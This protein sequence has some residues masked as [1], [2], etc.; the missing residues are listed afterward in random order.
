MQQNMS[1]QEHSGLLRNMTRQENQT[2]EQNLE[3]FTHIER[4]DES[5]S[6]GTFDESIHI[7]LSD[8]GV[9][10]GELNANDSEVIV[11]Q[12]TR[13][14][15]EALNEVD[16]TYWKRDN[17]T[18]GEQNPMTDAHQV[19]INS[20]E[21]EE[22]EEAE[23]VAVE[24]VRQEML[25]WEEQS[26]FALN[27]SIEMMTEENNQINKELD[28]LTSKTVHKRD[29]MAVPAADSHPT[30][31]RQVRAQ[32]PVL[33]A[34]PSLLVVCLPVVM[35]VAAVLV[36]RLYWRDG[37]R[38]RMLLDSEM[39]GPCLTQRLSSHP[40]IV[41]EN[42]YRRKVAIPLCDKPSFTNYYQDMVPRKRSFD[43]EE[44]R[45]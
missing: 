11:I 4:E 36:Y 25:P 8:E 21:K 29:I 16:D 35:A 10:G 17:I 43:K 14:L 44:T 32:A 33:A 19:D 13:T 31:E 7:V 20:K 41:I 39:A 2:E 28:I 27:K 26:Q 15:D 38:K 1:M 30:I 40:Q 5:S 34:M 18:G 9:L 23:E 42:D 6:S 45:S 24:T 12:S 22:T 37:H 3:T